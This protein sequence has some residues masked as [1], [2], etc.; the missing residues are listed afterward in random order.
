MAFEPGDR[1]RLRNRPAHKE[2]SIKLVCDGYIVCESWAGS[3][4]IVGSW[5]AEALEP[6]IFAPLIIHWPPTARRQ[7]D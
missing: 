7:R 1:V 4:I 2:M 3:G 5:P 6:V